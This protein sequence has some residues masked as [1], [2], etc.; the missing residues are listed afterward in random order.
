MYLFLLTIFMGNLTLTMDSDDDS[1][2][3]DIVTY[4]LEYNEDSVSVASD[5]SEKESYYFKS[6]AQHAQNMQELK[7]ALDD[8]RNE[9]AK[10]SHY[11]QTHR[12]KHP[13]LSVCHRKL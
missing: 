7:D 11:M 2:Y 10:I 8:Q 9:Y 12:A 6:E 4:S 13:Q 3:G 5:T 1:D